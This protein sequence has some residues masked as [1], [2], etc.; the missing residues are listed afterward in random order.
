M[1]LGEGNQTLVA[2]QP[3]GILD[4]KTGK[5]IGHDDPF[6][7]QMRADLSDKAFSLPLPMI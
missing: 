2:Q 7:S 5:P 4:P 1:G 6:V 3:K